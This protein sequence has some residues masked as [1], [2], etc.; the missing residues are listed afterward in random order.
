[1]SNLGS[2]EKKLPR[3]FANRETVRRIVQQKLAISMATA[4]AI[5]EKHQL[6]RLMTLKPLEANPMNSICELVS[7]QGGSFILKIQ[8]RPGIGSLKGEHYAIHLL[9]QLT[10][11]PVSDLCTLDDDKD[12]IPYPYLLSNKLSGESG[13][14]FFERTDHANR[15]Q[16]SEALGHIVGVIHRLEVREPEQLRNCDLNQWQGIVKEALLSDENFREEIAALS[17]TFYSQLSDLMASVSALQIDDE[18]VLLWGDP[19]FYNL[20][21]KSSGSK[22]QIAGLYDFQFA[23]YGSRLFD[24]YKIEGDFRVRHPREIYGHPEYIK[25]FYKGYEGAGQAVNAPSDTHQILVNIIRN[26]IQVRYWWWDCFDI[27]HPKTSEYLKA[28][29]VGL[30]ELSSKKV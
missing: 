13:Y 26:A 15:M 5:L 2:E 9:R 19:F 25:Q 7:E 17:D 24:F 23:A 8:Y 27:L 1:M 30:A 14:D 3:Q 12:I 28:I 22:V 11:L 6:G 4:S 21:V 16:L 20:L 18:P 29:L 10:D